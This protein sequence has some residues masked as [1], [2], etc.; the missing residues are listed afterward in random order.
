MVQLIKKHIHICIV[1]FGVQIIYY[2]LDVTC[3]ILLLT[4]KTCPTCGS[5]RAILSLLRGNVEMYVSYQPMAVP[6]AIAVIL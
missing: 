3:P 2:L 4:G 6:L 1:L 5:T